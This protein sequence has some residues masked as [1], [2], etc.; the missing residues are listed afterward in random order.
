MLDIGAKDALDAD[1]DVVVI[2]G[3]VNGT[4]IALDAAGRGLKVL[5]CEMN[6]L[7]G[8]TSSAS[9]K[10]IHGGLRYLEQY[11]F[12]LVR[13]AL[14]ERERLLR[15]AP[16]IMR[17]LRFRLPHRP[18][19]RPA[20]MIRA[21]LFLYDNLARRLVSGPSHAIRFREKSPLKREMH[22]GYEYSDGWVDDARLVVLLA[23][24]AKALGA[25]IHPRT[26]CIAARRE[27]G[28]WLVTL[29]NQQT[30][31]VLTRSCRTLVNATG[32]WV[33]SLFREVID[34]SSPHSIRL[35]K[36]SHIVVPRLHDAPEA[37][38]LQNQDGR[39]VFVIPFEDV[40]SLVG[41]T[42]VDF[43]GDATDVAI[44]RD[45]I[46]YLLSVINAHFMTQTTSNEIVWSYSGVRPLM[47]DDTTKA[48]MASRDYELEL[49]VGQAGNEAPL[50]S[51]FGGK[52]TTYRILSEAAVDHLRGTFPGMGERWTARNPLPGGAIESIDAFKAELEASYSWLPNKMLSRFA[53]SYGTLCH[54]FLSGCQSL[55]D[56]GQHIGDTL[57]EAEVRYLVELEWART[58]EDILWRRS[59]LGLHLTL[60]EIAVLEQILESILLQKTPYD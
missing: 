15:N 35:V 22:C 4:G 25:E 55:D 27:A 24:G 11:D 58:S 52:I 56:L 40:Y 38:I 44:S 42:D 1:F 33:E 8:A 9:S 31:E 19:L 6:D 23:R 53:R 50:L 14:K 29:R 39:I 51:V 26:K 17:P 37:Y 47:D 7:G 54:Q 2:G 16:H 28:I 21:G 36:G 60:K 43:D 3:G 5:L 59:K 48:Q 57:Y 10:L 46:D 20:W 12:G 18:H 13:K 41:T 32:P 45:E 49:D 34:S 30:G